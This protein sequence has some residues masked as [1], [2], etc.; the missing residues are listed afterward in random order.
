MNDVLVP[1]ASSGGWALESLFKKYK[2]SFLFEKSALI[3]LNMTE[4]FFGYR[5]ACDTAHE[6]L[7]QTRF[8][9]FRAFCSENKF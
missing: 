4:N 8:F 3:S 2:F 6:N 7:Y 1:G 5:D 9:I